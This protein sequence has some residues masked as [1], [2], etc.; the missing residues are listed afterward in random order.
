MY[1]RCD[2][3]NPNYGIDFYYL[4]FSISTFALMPKQQ[5]IKAWFPDDQPDAAKEPALA[6]VPPWP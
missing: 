2:T 3:I 5:K 6:K 4:S 1:C